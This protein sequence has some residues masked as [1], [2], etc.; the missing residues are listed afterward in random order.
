MTTCFELDTGTA[1]LGKWWFPGGNFLLIPEASR[2]GSCVCEKFSG[3][4]VASE[5]IERPQPVWEPCVRTRELRVAFGFLL[6]HSQL[7]SWVV[8]SLHHVSR[9]FGS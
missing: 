8:A 5:V 1:V 6:P 2:D 4:G 7:V 3:P 9:F